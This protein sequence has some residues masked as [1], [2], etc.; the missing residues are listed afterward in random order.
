MVGVPAVGDSRKRPELARQAYPCVIKDEHQ[1]A[2]C[3]SV[4]RRTV[5][6]ALGSRE[7]PLSAQWVADDSPFPD[8]GLRFSTLMPQALRP[9]QSRERPAFPLAYRNF[10]RSTSPT[11]CSTGESSLTTSA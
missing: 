2:A 10:F 4:W 11:R 7:P 8:S 6:Q 1:E 9:R 3:R 5:R